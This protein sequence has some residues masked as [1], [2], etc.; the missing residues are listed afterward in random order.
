MRLHHPIVPGISAYVTGLFRVL[1]LALS[2]ARVLA[3][4]SRRQGPCR[5]Q[6]GVL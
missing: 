6:A 1:S 3:N 2:A 5:Q 4:T